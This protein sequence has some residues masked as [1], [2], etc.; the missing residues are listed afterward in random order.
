MSPPCRIFPLIASSPPRSCSNCLALSSGPP[1]P[2][3]SP[4]LN[5]LQQKY[6]NQHFSK[7]HD[8]TCKEEMNLLSST[9]VNPALRHISIVARAGRRRA[10]RHFGAGELVGDGFVYTGFLQTTQP[11]SDFA[12]LTI[13]GSMIEVS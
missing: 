9:R 13:V 10:G 12:R 1:W 4:A 6:N 11:I 5:G 3:K 7:K 2:S 8:T